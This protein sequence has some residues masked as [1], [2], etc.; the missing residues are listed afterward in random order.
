MQL[1]NV[2]E[3]DTIVFSTPP[4]K[5][6]KKLL[7]VLKVKV[8]LRKLAQAKNEILVSGGGADGLK[9]LLPQLSPKSPVDHVVP[10]PD[11]SQQLWICGDFSLRLVSWAEDL[12]QE[13]ARGKHPLCVIDGHHVTL[14]SGAEET[15]ELARKARKAGKQLTD[16]PKA[17]FSPRELVSE[18][19]RISPETRYV[20]TSHLKGQGVTTEE[21]AQYES[22]PQVVK[23]MGRTDTPANQR[24]LL[25]LARKL[26]TSA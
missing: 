14:R 9:A 5:D 4:A 2:Q 16:Y 19:V 8:V 17:H 21:R 26:Y 18:L 24:Y 11:C 15:V 13:L 22:F 12:F 1:P 20:F 3:G 23:V 7:S 6:I 25:S 10:K